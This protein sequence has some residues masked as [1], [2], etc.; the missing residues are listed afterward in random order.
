MEY[1]F[2]LQ[3]LLNII[4]SISMVRSQIEA[5]FDVYKADAAIKDSVPW[6]IDVPSFDYTG[7]V[8]AALGMEVPKK[9]RFYLQSE[10]VYNRI[11]LSKR[12]AGMNAST[13]QQLTK[14]MT[15]GLNDATKARI[16]LFI[17]DVR[18][19]IFAEQRRQLNLSIESAKNKHLLEVQLSE[20]FL[21]VLNDV[22]KGNVQPQ[23]SNTV[24][25]TLSSASD[26]SCI[27]S[28]SQLPKKLKLDEVLNEMDVDEI[29]RILS[30]LD[31]KRN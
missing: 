8:N 26:Q 29:K 18:S 30:S 22:K 23:N 11:Q 1:N 25:S 16:E 3:S 21:D 4:E 24:D 19:L 15:N 2:S 20:R 12:S 27:Q 9:P 5:Q 6:G 28:G 10:L 17:N 7:H 14:N 31:G 13:R